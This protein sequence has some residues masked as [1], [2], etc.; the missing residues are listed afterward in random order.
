MAVKVQIPTPM[1]QHT[2][3]KA[4]LP[5]IPAELGVDPLLLAVLHTVVFLTGSAEGIVEPEAAEETLEYLVT[6]LQRLDG[7]RLGRI[8]EDLLTLA[9]YA[10]QQ[11]WSKQ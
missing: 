1:R 3:G 9:G 6:Y 8:R 2:E 5:L 4:V 7:P 10:K 11:E